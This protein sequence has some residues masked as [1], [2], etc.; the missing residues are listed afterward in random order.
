MVRHTLTGRCLLQH[1]WGPHAG[2]AER[3]F[4]FDDVA[5]W[6]KLSR[7]GDAIDWTIARLHD[8][9]EVCVV[10]KEQNTEARASLG[11]ILRAL[12]LPT[13]YPTR[14]NPVFLR[15]GVV[16]PRCAIKRERIRDCGPAQYHYRVSAP[17]GW[18]FPDGYHER[19]EDT[20]GH[21]DLASRTIEKCPSDWDCDCGNGAETSTARNER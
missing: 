14:S 6:G 20:R 12:V 16:K 8:G 9:A 2:G 19:F 18:Q 21:A 11:K 17:S 5:A 7:Y 1:E 3:T 15:Y 10:A 4:A 13:G